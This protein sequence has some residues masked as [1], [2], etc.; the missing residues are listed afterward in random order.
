MDKE[1]WIATYIAAFGGTPVVAAGLGYVA[2]YDFGFS[3]QEIRN[4]AMIATLFLAALMLALEYF[5][6]RKSK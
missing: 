6:W 3:R 5:C 2:H 1:F 4:G